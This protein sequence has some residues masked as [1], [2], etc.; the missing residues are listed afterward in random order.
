VQAKNKDGSSPDNKE[1]TGLIMPAGCS[2][3]KI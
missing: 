2:D 1:H 3:Y